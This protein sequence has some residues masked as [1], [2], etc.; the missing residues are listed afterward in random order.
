MIKFFIHTA[1]CQQFFMGTG[2]RNPIFCQNQNFC[3][4]WIVVR[5]W[6]ITNVV[7]FF[8]SF[9]NDSC[10]TLSLSLS[11]AEVASSKIRTGGFFKK[12]GLWKAAASA[13]RRA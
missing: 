4:F 10:T 8:A 5:R 6:A 9:S 2:F 12:H 13:L 1:P 3:A 7:R 11:S